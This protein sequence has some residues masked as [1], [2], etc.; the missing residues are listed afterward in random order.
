MYLGFFFY[1]ILFL[2]VHLYRYVINLKNKYVNMIKSGKAKQRNI[3]KKKQ[4]SFHSLWNEEGSDSVLSAYLAKNDRNSKFMH[5]SQC[6]PLLIFSIYLCIY[7]RKLLLRSF[8]TIRGFF[9]TEVID[10]F[11]LAPLIIKEDNIVNQTILRH[12]GK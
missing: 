11:F 10:Y 1:L 12:K 9:V 6:N 2:E 5:L 7:A 3:L 4:P 8:T